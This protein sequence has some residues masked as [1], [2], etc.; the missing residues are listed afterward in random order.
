M[1]YACIARHRAEHD[2]RLMCRVLS[3]S[4]AGYYAW[5][6]RSPCAR[7]LA[8]ARLLLNIRIAHRKS[9]RR[10]GAPRVHHELQAQGY[11]VGQ[12]R[13]ARLM[14]QAG[15]VGR[16]R[17]RR[18]P[19]TTDSS[20][21][22]P[23]APNHLARQFDV[24]G[25]ALNRVWVADL[26]YIPTGD[27]WL[28]LA[29]VLDLASR[30]CIGWAMGETLETE[31]ALRALR[32]ALAARQPAPG[33]LHHSDRGCQFADGRYRALLEAHG[34]V[35]SMSRKGDCWDNA[36]AESFF[37]TLEFELIEGSR[38]RTRDEARRAIFEFIEVW[39]NRERQHSTLGYISPVQ[40]ERQL[41]A[42]A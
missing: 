20:H 24:N 8:D 22:G 33:C 31:L 3:V 15:L 40:Y 10:Y 35:A 12:K 5:R 30:R 9:R 29:T 37:A 19:R 39:Y 4:P 32:M 42:A 18:R 23:I 27:G 28:Y 16:A 25:I 41:Q 1:R 21:G 6:R 17:S 34:L 26:T 38:W 7:A 14:R 13:V 11:R 2:L 36:V